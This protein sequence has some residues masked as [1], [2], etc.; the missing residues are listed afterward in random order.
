VHGKDTYC[1]IYMVVITFYSLFLLFFLLQDSLPLRYDRSR[2]RI[3]AIQTV[4]LFNSIVTGEVTKGEGLRRDKV[5][6]TMVHGCCCLFLSFF[7]SP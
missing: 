3:C 5:I 7:V 6:Y 4:R 2:G 1:Y